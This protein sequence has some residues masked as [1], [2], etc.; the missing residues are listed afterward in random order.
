MPEPGIVDAQVH[1]WGANTPERPWPAGRDHLAQK[2]YPVTKELILAG[3]DEAGIDRVVLVPPSWEGDRNDLALEAARL[4]PNRFAVMGRIDLATPQPELIPTWRKQQGMLGLR[5]TFHRGEQRPWLT[6]GTAEWA[7]KACEENDVPLMVFVP[8]SVPA[9]GEVAERHPG[10]KL[11]IDHLACAGEP[12]PERFNH[13]A[14]VL[15]LAKYPNVAVKASA[16]P[17]MTTETYPFPG[18]QPIIRRVFDAFG[19]ERTF[20]GTDWTRLPCTWREARDLFEVECDFLKGED[21][22][23]VMGGAICQWLGWE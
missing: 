13:L 12:G 8:G 20:W 16:L 6:D 2:P 5:F 18:L 11:V 4:H 9:I 14:E 15:A 10:L 23:M 22:E 3:M 17:C 1:I 7:W 19:P 21:L